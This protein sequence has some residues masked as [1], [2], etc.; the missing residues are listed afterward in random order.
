MAH[1]VKTHQRREGGGGILGKI[2][3]VYTSTKGVVSLKLSET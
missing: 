2:I 1:E 3:Y